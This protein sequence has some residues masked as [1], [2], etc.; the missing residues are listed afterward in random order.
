MSD[1]IAAGIRELGVQPG[2]RMALMVPPGIL[3]VAYVFGLFKAGVVVILID[4]GMGRKNMIRCLAE[5]K[6]IGMVG[7]P[8]AH[9]ARMIFR[10]RLVRCKKNVSVGGFFPGCQRDLHLRMP[11]SK[12]VPQSES[13]TMSPEDPAA[14]IFT[15]GS[16]GPPKGVLYR[17]RNFI[18][19]AQQIRDYFDIQP[20]GCDISGFPLFALFNTAMGT[21]TVFP[22]MDPTRPAQI[23][24]PNFIDAVEQF[25]ANQ[26]FGSPALWNT[27]STYC[28]KH[29]VRLPTIKRILT[30]GAPVP[31][32]VLQKIRKVIAPDG[33]AFTPYGATES[34]PVACNSATEVLGETAAK[35]H[36]GAGTCVGKRFPKIDWQVIEISDHSIP[37]IEQAQILP[38]GEIGELI[39][40]GPVVTDQ[41]VTRT[42][43]NAEHKVSDGD[44][45]WHR[46]GDVGYLDDQQRFWFC[47]R[48][49]HRVVTSAE[50]LFTI[51]CEAILNTLQPVYRSALVGV[52]ALGKQVPVLIL[53]PTSWPGSKTA[54]A[55]L[56]Q[57]AREL[58]SQHQTTKSISHFLLHKSLPVDIRHNSKI[59]REQLRDWAAERI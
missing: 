45:F 4:P 14:I 24:P 16:T 39:V 3:F 32:I 5:A 22:E 57:R 36:L 21:T 38:P 51:Q 11:D 6:P 52:G 53:E 41:Y 48:K 59:F 34:L 54:Q 44:S 43:A 58:A 26:S 15:T 20:G 17:H 49:S 9:V 33:D 31:P 37:T 13:T 56:L 7:I 25:S 19:Q 28:E 42:E 46:M 47:G 2:E 55:E 8:L 35:T 29:D 1:R 12:A 30:A 40:R 27:V 18:E 23:Y 50:T 10:R